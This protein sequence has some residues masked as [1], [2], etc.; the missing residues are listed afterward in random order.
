[1]LNTDEIDPDPEGIARG[2][3]G[4]VLAVAAPAAPRLGGGARSQSTRP[5]E[6]GAAPHSRRAPHGAGDRARA[7]P[8]R[9]GGSGTHRAGVAPPDVIDGTAQSVTDGGSV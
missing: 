8:R 7:R 1:M 2:L 9:R 5:G 3:T 4:A 6:R